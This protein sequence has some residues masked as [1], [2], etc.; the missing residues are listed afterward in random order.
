MRDFKFFKNETV[1]VINMSDYEL[2]TTTISD[3]DYNILI[4]TFRP[5]R[6]EDCDFCFQF[7]DNDPIVFGHGPNEL[8]MTINPTTNGSI[9]FNDNGKRFKIFARQRPN[10]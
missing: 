10:G 4:Y 3:N 2:T 6:I 8:T 5:T 1:G 7:D 9:I